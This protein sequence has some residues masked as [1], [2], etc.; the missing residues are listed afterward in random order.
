MPNIYYGQV[1]FAERLAAYAS[2]GRIRLRHGIFSA[3]RHRILK[4]VLDAALHDRVRLAAKFIDKI[5]FKPRE[6]SD[7]VALTQV[8]FQTAPRN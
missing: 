1:N 5:A 7:F 8:V 4:H 3:A 6:N 2:W